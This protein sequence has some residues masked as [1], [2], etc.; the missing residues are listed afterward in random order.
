MV[1][2]SRPCEYYRR[3]RCLFVRIILAERAGF[4]FGVKRAIDLAM[5]V[6]GEEEGSGQ[7]SSL[8]PLIHNPQTVERLKAAGIRV[9]D[10]LDAIQEG[11][12]IIRSHGVPPDVIAQAENRGL[13]VVDATCPFVR[14]AMDWAAELFAEGYQVVIVG[15]RNHPEVAAVRAYTKNTAVVIKSASEAEKVPFS[16]R[17]GVVAQTTQSSDNFRGCLEVLRGRCEEL[18]VF[19]SICT[20]TTQRQEM[21]A[22]LAAKADIMLVVGGRNS[23]NT[24]RLAEICSEAGAFTYHI[25]TRDE[26]KPEWF[27]LRTDRE[28][29]V[30]ITAGASTPNWLIEEVVE[31]MNEL[32]EKN[33]EQGVNDEVV[34]KAEV[35]GETPAAAGAAGGTNLAEA[36]ESPVGKEDEPVAAPTMEQY[37]ETFNTPAQGEIVVGKVVQVNDEEVLVHVGGKSEGRIPRNELGLKANQTPADVVSVG[38][39]IDVYVI[40]VEDGEGTVLLSK[41]RADQ[42]GAWE[43]LEKI[44]EEKGIIE[45]EVTERVKGG[46]LID[47]GVR[48]FVPA[49]HVDRNYVEDLD[50]YV[51]QTFRVRIIELDRQR[52]NV[53]L[54]R[55][56][57]LEEDYQKA[58]EET[59]ANLQEGDVVDG[60][61]RRLTDFGAFVD[62]GSGVEGLLHVS[63]MAYSR[64]DHPS[65]VLAEGDEIK[66]MILR[67]DR[68]RERISLGLKQTLP[69][70]WDNISDKYRVGDKVTG[71]VTRVVDF[72]AFVKLE[73]GVEGLVHISQ[74]A[75]HHVVN[76]SD[77]VSPGQ[78]VL[79]KV[80]SID[81]DQRRIGLSIREA[82]DKPAA[83]KRQEKP[84]EHQPTSYQSMPED[85]NDGGLA[86]IG[87]LVGKDLRSLFEKK[88]D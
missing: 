31:R 82:V 46:L 45:A 78:E 66:V 34:D 22:K 44:Y 2:N 32:N 26:I 81:E 21:A 65:D 63:E 75:D 20:A 56:E 86:N 28:L 36:K 51:G 16:P 9:A 1:C 55:K 87:E 29:I 4:C 6:A 80:I 59:F 5:K 49:S 77:V 11:V 24:T 62:I 17:L 35:T 84:K 70:P 7:I 15:D 72:G 37:D 23:A 73:D 58:K 19:D 33:Q 74:L 88:D 41:R 47:V 10:S 83:P 50:Q 13:R 69:D 61:V 60:V 52:N 12:V 76:A 42:R 85:N 18:K 64:V 71:E 48:G 39:E 40:R 53:V 8:G 25:E 57:V 14:R 68:E 3:E 79:V 54:S 43:E 27:S 30:G 67:I 38:D